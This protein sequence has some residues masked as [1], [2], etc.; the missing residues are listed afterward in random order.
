MLLV[1]GISKV[2]PSVVTSTSVATREVVTTDATDSITDAKA[3][4]VEES[5][6]ESGKEQPTESSFPG[7]YSSSSSVEEKTSLADFGPRSG[8]LPVTSSPSS[9]FE[10]EKTSFTDQGVVDGISIRLV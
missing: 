10:E 8:V 6:E 7:V 2:L 5:V 1:A 3:V 4:L 9:S